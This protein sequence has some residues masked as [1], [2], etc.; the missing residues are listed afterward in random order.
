[1]PGKRS[2]SGPGAREEPA[3]DRARRPGVVPAPLPPGKGPKVFAEFFRREKPGPGSRSPGKANPPSISPNPR[4]HPRLPGSSRSPRG[5][6]GFGGFP[7]YSW[8]G[9]KRGKK[10]VKKIYVAG[11]SACWRGPNPAA[12]PAAGQGRPRSPFAGKTRC[13]LPRERRFPK[14]RKR[15]ALGAGTRTRCP[16]AAAILPSS[17]RGF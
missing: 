15:I 14:Q 17:R 13:V 5:C 16:S 12:D 2:S 7:G 8:L 6:A 10:N 9:E 4:D 1:M 11:F 3:P